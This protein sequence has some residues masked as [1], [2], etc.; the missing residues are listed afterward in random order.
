M[1]PAL[2]SAICWKLFHFFY[3][4][5]QSAGNLFDLNLIGI[6]RD[7]TPELSVVNIAMVSTS[8]TLNKN[9]NPFCCYLA[10]LIEGKGSI[11]LPK[12]DISPKGKLNYPSINLVF[13]LRDF[14]LCQLIQKE[15]G[16]GSLSRMKGNNSYLLEINS[17]EGVLK[18]VNL[19][20]GNMRTSKIH[21]LYKLI[22][23]LNNKN[24]DLN[25]IKKQLDSSPIDSNAWLSG[26]IDADASFS[27]FLN[28]NSIRIRF[29]LTQSSKIK[30]GISNEA[31]MN[32]IAEYLEVKVSTIQR[33]VSPN[34]IELTVK[35][36][37]IKS[38]NNLINYLTKYP[39]WSSNF[40]NYSD[41]LFALDL[42]KKVYKTKNKSEEVFYEIKKI[43][44]EMNDK[45]VKFNWDHLIQFYNLD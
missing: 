15:L 23:W 24:N 11:I 8:S 4:E 7:Y 21:C 42:F 3:L 38:N 39:L 5:T 36:Q 34:S 16:T 27:I 1:L 2:N 18:L 33:K 10:G 14:P 20:N 43:K 6:L 22:D 25:L 13:H 31:I 30:L 35:T 45:R 44:G 28:K 32:I 17:F 37:S 40:L 9:S 41:W 26:F 29:S 12:T 19:L